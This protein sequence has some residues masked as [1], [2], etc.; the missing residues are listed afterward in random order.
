MYVWVWWGR[1]AA[2]Y[3][4]KLKCMLEHINT[5]K[6]WHKNPL[7]FVL[8]HTQGE[9]LL[10]RNG[11]AVS[12]NS[13]SSKFWLR[14][15]FWTFAP[16]RKGW[17]TGSKCGL[18]VAGLCSGRI[19]AFLI[20]LWKWERLV[21]PSAPSISVWLPISESIS[22]RIFGRLWARSTPDNLLTYG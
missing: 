1:S 3:V 4:L 2:Q 19:Q 17:L 10:G 15:S 16:P 18:I 21:D 7:H 22:G 12:R 9:C 20:Q 5:N 11:Y 13:A 6:R 8:P 14:G